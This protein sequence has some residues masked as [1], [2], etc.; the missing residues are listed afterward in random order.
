MWHE[1]L[2]VFASD[3]GSPVHV[4]GTAGTNSPLRGGK[5]TYWEGG[6]RTPAF[7][8][9]GWLPRRMRSRRLTGLV[10]ISDLFA[11][12]C[13]VASGDGA[14]RPRHQKLGPIPA[15]LSSVVLRTTHTP[16]QT[17]AQHLSPTLEV[18]V[19]RYPKPE[20]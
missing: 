20:A 5:G 1:T 7:I 14:V 9:G 3:N 16:A 13:A 18:A 2:F 10:H 12:F 17:Q 4:W 11:S 6:I 15:L 19:S 8:S